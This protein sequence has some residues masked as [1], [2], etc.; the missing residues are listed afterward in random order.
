MIEPI[1]AKQESL[2]GSDGKQPKPVFTNKIMYSCFLRWTVENQ[3]RTDIA[4]SCLFTQHEIVWLR[5][6]NYSGSG[7]VSENVIDSSFAGEQGT[8]D[9]L[10]YFT[11]SIAWLLDL[12]WKAGGPPLRCSTVQ[13]WSNLLLARHS[14]EFA[15]NTNNKSQ[16]NVRNELE[17]GHGLIKDLFVKT[18]KDTVLN[19][20]WLQLQVESVWAKFT[21]CVW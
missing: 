17:H 13:S 19:D 8:S 3:V 16:A 5:H 15:A 1:K 20:T 7:L 18:L 21:F 12:H 6:L 4:Q 10:V 9:C 14:N 11:L 2:I